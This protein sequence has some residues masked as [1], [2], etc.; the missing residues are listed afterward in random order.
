M[1][2]I[3]MPTTDLGALF[4]NLWMRAADAAIARNRI[5]DAALRE[6][7]RDR[8]RRPPG[9]VGSFIAEPLFEAMFGWYA[10]DRTMQQLADEGLL[11]PALVAAL[12]NDQPITA[13]GRQE[14]NTFSRRRAPYRHQLESWRRLRSDPP[15]PL[16]VTSGTGSG[17]TECFLVPILDDLYRQRDRLGRLIGVQALFL[18]PLNALI[19][20]QQDRLSDWTEPA[21]GEIRFCLY[22]GNTPPQ[23]RQDEMARTPWEVRDRHTLRSA[24]PP[25]LVTNA[26]MLEYMLVRA[27]DASI[28]AHSCGRLRWIVLD[29]AH[30]YVGSQAAEMALLLR[31][32]LH[33]FGV[34]PDKVRFIAT[35]ATLGEGDAS[36]QGLREFVARLSG[37]LVDDVDVVVGERHV[38]VLSP[39]THGG[40]SDDPAACRVREALACGPATLSKLSALCGD[41]NV[42]D[43][44]GYA[45]LAAE[46]KQP[47][48][49]PLRVHL[50]HRAQPG[51][52]AC[53]NPGCSGRSGTRLDN[54]SWPFGN[55]LVRDAPTCSDCGGITLQVVVCDECGVP[56]LEAG[57]TAAR[58]IRR[59]CE[60]RDID[61]F[62]AEAETEEEEPDDSLGQETD[63]RVLLAQSGLP[64]GAVLVIDPIT[65]LTPDVEQEGLIRLGRH[66][67]NDGCPS[68]RARNSAQ[69]RLFRPLRLGGPFMVANAAN[70][71]LDAAPEGETPT[72]S[73]HRGRQMLTF[74]DNRQGTA[75]L[76]AT[77]QRDA[78]R[79]YARA[80]L[81]HAVTVGDPNTAGREADLQRELDTLVSVRQPTLD[82]II[83]RKRAELSKLRAGGLTW[84][85]AKLQLGASNKEQPGLHQVWSGR[86]LAFSED[87]ALANL[88]LHAEFLRR[89]TRSNNLETMGLVALRFDAIEDAQ[90]VPELFAERGATI[91]DW[92]DFLSIIVTHMLR[93]SRAVN[94]TDSLRNWIGQRAFPRIFVPADADGGLRRTEVRW[95]MIRQ[96]GFQQSRIVRL[97]VHGLNLD[98]GDVRTTN[99]ANDA[100]MQAFTMLRSGT[101]IQPRW[102]NLQLDLTRARL[103][104]LDWAF[105]CPITLR[106]LDRCFLS[107]TPYVPMVPGSRDLVCRVLK[108]P[109]LPYPWLRDANG[110]DRRAEAESWL[111]K[112]EAVESLRRDGVWTDLHDRLV[113][114]SPFIRVAEHSAQQPGSRLRRYERDFKTGKINVL[115]CST[116]MELGVDI[117]GVTT[118]AMTNVPPSPTNYRQRVGRAGRRQEPLATYC[119]DDPLGWAMFDR[120]TEIL[121]RAIRPPRVALESRPIVRRHVN[122]FL[123]GQYLASS[124]CPAAQDRTRL[125][126]VWFFGPADDE[127][128]PSK[129]F[130]NW[131]RARFNDAVLNEALARLVAG[132]ALAGAPDLIEVCA[133]EIQKFALAWC[134]ERDAIVADLAGAQ[135]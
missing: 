73:P 6:A 30:T 9:E 135:G 128:P 72:R 95:P 54:S 23:V 81:F 86:D 49:L 35:S 21:N 101:G 92:R 33:A 16:V 134:S 103:V 91:Q 85:Q 77:W 114:L 127:N 53:V 107:I 57:D 65:G 116:T 39:R 37:R 79:G 22:N 120:P 125:P 36:R 31:R 100:L 106:L 59:W 132:T 18:Y 84:E 78:E 104:G 7:L 13:T 60:R 98:L 102:P 68:C 4:A 70:V 74:S 47:A 12:A 14:R 29:E 90:S 46:E 121:E 122:A 87:Q 3:R 41:W 17:K 43:L 110:E 62:A 28:L 112:D 63:E 8:V 34:T 88:Q 19:A 89:P 51:I 113:L 38:P 45:R 118:V 75:R 52:W 61:D 56:F 66:S 40:L 26:T 117:G 11:H 108:M 123:L 109:T 97:L 2:V 83:A 10:A 80:V 93:A 133:Q 67:P 25:I 71:L 69:R 111:R 24:P 50:F 64:G 42:L 124:D 32:T 126:A 115:A 99:L 105:A 76:A 119:P 96:S 44:L 129:G 55:I 27:A 1:K 94:I 20:S 48:F 131:L 5:V 82:P 15:R 130:A 58:R